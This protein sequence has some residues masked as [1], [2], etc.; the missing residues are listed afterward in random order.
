MSRKHLPAA[1]GAADGEL[2]GIAQQV[3]KDLLEPPWVRRELA[4]IIRAV[5]HEAVLVLLGELTGGPD[6]LVDHACDVRA[7]PGNLHRTISGVSA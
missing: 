4:E 6:H 5:H 2:G 3:E 7:G 1:A